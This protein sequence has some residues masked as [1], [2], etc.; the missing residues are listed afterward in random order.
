MD[1]L[2]AFGHVE[3]DDDWLTIRPIDPERIPDVVAAV[4]AAGGRVHAVDPGRRS[5]ED[6]F[7]GLVQPPVGVP[8]PTG[9]VGHPDPG[10][11]APGAPEAS[12]AAGPRGAAR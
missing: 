11:G 7:L 2:A 3:R 8:A 1:P 12:G 5:L 4:V 10:A 9:D 6:L